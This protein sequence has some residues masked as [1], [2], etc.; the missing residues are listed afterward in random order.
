MPVK[1]DSPDVFPRLVTWKEGQEYI[2]KLAKYL[3]WMIAEGFIVW[4]DSKGEYQ[5]FLAQVAL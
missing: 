1:Y 2:P 5:G 4:R 3:N